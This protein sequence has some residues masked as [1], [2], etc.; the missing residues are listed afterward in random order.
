MKK[1]T[2]LLGVVTFVLAIGYIYGEETPI[3]AENS[4]FSPIQI[5]SKVP[6]PMER[7]AI[8]HVQAD[9]ESNLFTGEN[10]ET[11]SVMNEALWYVDSA[12]EEFALTLESGNQPVYTNASGSTFDVT[13]TWG[14][15][16]SEPGL[17]LVADP[18]KTTMSS[19][20]TYSGVVTW[21]IMAGQP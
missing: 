5:E 3:E 21:T 20:G 6:I 8:E 10:D 1:I 18:T 7:T 9:E 2:R 12:G 19:T 16:S 14:D 15:T 17:K 11:G 13:G 4:G